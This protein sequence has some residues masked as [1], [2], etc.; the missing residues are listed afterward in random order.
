MN[1]S[2]YDQVNQPT[3]VF[4][5]SQRRLTGVVTWERA[6]SQKPM[7]GIVSIVTPH[8]D[9]RAKAARMHNNE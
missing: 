5:N 2:A 1:E 3:A 9:D 8:L 7:D 4:E 6:E